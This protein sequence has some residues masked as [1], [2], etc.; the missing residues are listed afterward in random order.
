MV[1][2]P[3][4][5]RALEGYGDRVQVLAAGGIVTGRQMAAC[6]AMGAAGVWTGSVWLTT[7]EAETLPTVK[8]QKLAATSREPVRQRGRTG[9]Y[10][11][12]LRHAWTDACNS[13]AAP[14]PLPLPLLRLPSRTALHPA[15]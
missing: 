5:M 2:V 9:T 10:T 7:A 8:E 13:P 11:R 12:P 14:T 6:M 1:L 15:A 3:E 4:V